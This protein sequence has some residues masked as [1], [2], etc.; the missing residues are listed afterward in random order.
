[1][2]EDPNNN[3]HETNNKSGTLEELQ[4]SKENGNEQNSAAANNTNGNQPT[5]SGGP[6]HVYVLETDAPISKP[7]ETATK[8]FTVRCGK[9]SGDFKKKYPP[10]SVRRGCSKQC[11]GYNK[12]Q[13]TS[14]Y[15]VS[16]V[17]FIR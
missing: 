1:M 12:N 7:E 11:A 2:H 14:R 9:N 5:S 15:S 4:P 16:A 6:V 8:V 10:P 17:L 13:D 3:W